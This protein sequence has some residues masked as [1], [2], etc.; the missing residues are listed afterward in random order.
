MQNLDVIKK[1]GIKVAV[2]KKGELPLSS[3]FDFRLNPGYCLYNGAAVVQQRGAYICFATENEDDIVLRGRLERAFRNHLSYVLKEKEIPGVFRE[4]PRIDFVTKSHEEIRAIVSRLYMDSELAGKVKD[5]SSDYPKENE[6]AAAVILLD[7]LLKEG[8]K[9]GA[10]DIHIENGKIRMRVKGRLQ[11]FGMVSR[12]REK[13]LLI[14]IKLLAGM[15]L[16]EKRKSQDGSFCYGER[17]PLFVRVSSVGIVGS[18][19]EDSDESVVM[20]LLDTKR[21][22]LVLEKLGFNEEQLIAIQVLSSFPNGL[23]L[24]CGATSSGKS[25]TAA[26]ILLELARKNGNRQKIITLE[27][28][29]EYMIPGVTQ[30]KAGKSSGNQFSTLLESVFRQDPDVLMIGEVRDEQTAKTALRASLTGHLVLATIH[31]DDVA[32]AVFRLEELGLDRRLV[33]SVLR[34]VI[35]QELHHEEDEVRLVCDVATAKEEFAADADEKMTATQIEDDFIHSTN[36]REAL[37]FWNES[38]KRRLLLSGKKEKLISSASGG[39][40]I[41]SGNLMEA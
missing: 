16:L 22:P 14:R 36:V 41:D 34:G 37:Y 3:R 7:S 39:R 21:L 26:S 32:S 40:F 13:E 6:D 17:E 5:E 15:N 12:E 30:I 35:V 24:I 9:N 25:T 2:E 28:P 19:Q 23:V 1:S 33:A 8:R 18:T 29:V 38:R 27:D 31:A 4:M 20:R 10:T 11:D